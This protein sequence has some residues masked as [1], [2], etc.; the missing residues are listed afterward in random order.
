MANP[1]PAEEARTRTGAAASPEVL[2][3][4]VY[5]QL[6]R[7]ARARLAAERGDS[8]RA[9]DL[10]HEAFLRLAGD[11]PEG[12]AGRAQYFAA[13]AVAMRR[14]LIDRARARSRQRRGGNKRRVPLAELDL[15]SAQDGDH[16][17]AID[18]ALQR[19]ERA[20]PRA[21][22]IVRMRFYGGLSEEET[23]AALDLSART[24]RREWVYGR[25]WLFAALRE[26][27]QN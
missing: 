7:L 4:V 18:E 27:D 17:L 11:R 21:A 13:A 20:D 10:V 9:T 15:A 24:V 1:D 16:V 12:W 2:V 25:A 23:A 19:L 26:P 14:I 8:L 5:E 3:P 22:A 6:R